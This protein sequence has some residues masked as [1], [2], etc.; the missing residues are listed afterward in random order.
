MKKSLLALAAAALLLLSGTAVWAVPTIQIDD[1]Q[2]AVPTVTFSDFAPNPDPT[3]TK[4][5]EWAFISGFVSGLPD[6][7]Q[8][9]SYLTE[10]NVPSTLA[11]V[12]DIAFFISTGGNFSVGFASDGATNIAFDIPG[13]GPVSFDT[14]ED[15]LDVFSSLDLF[16]FET[17]FHQPETGDYQEL[18]PSNDLAILSVQ[19]KSDVEPIPLPPSVWLL[20][21]GLLGL[22]GFRKKFMR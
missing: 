10:S 2:E 21:S 5:F 12:S 6:V 7:L 8:K 14:F 3:V 22:V 16:P 18:F 11:N 17:T 1:T 19:A 15:A 20:G 13:F 4:G 9:G